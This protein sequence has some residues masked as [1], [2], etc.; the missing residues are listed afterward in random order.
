M[1]TAHTVSSSP[2]QALPSSVALTTSSQ[3][4]RAADGENLQ[5]SAGGAAHRDTAG[6]AADVRHLPPCS[7]MPQA[8]AA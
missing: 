7:A 5:A 3:M 8:P 6:T 1:E 2:F 4:A